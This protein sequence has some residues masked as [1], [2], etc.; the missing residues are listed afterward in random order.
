MCIR[1]S[2]EPGRALNPSI[3][4]GR[5]VS[6]VFEISGMQKSDGLARSE[7]LLRMVQIADPGRVLRSYP[8]QPVSYTHL[9]VYKRQSQSPVKRYSP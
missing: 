9:D 2:Q 6:E 8:H 5:Q 4:V 1:D 7:E 3:R